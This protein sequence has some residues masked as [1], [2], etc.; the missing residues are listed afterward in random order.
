LRLGHALGA[1]SINGG[2]A[3]RSLS[4]AITPSFQ[5]LR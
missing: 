3:S 1:G 5:V 4:A 2:A